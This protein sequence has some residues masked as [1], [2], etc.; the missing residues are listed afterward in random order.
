MKK[1]LIII[2]ILL[3]LAYGAY[4]GFVGF[5]ERS[6]GAWVTAFIAVAMV[7]SILLCIRPK[8]IE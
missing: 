2:S 8:K 6:A 3:L 4:G 7:L 5:N 1:I